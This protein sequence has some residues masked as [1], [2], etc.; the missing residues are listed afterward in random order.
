MS[1]LAGVGFLSCLSILP[2]NFF[3]IKEVSSP[4]LSFSCENTKRTKKEVN[5]QDVIEYAY[6]YVYILPYINKAR[7][8]GNSNL[9]FRYI[10]FKFCP[11]MSMSPIL[12]PLPF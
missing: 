9:N 3:I 1:F 10:E 8:N 7:T 6:Q 5:T 2:G 4:F 12:R 11:L